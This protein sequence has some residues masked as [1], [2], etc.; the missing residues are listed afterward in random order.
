LLAIICRQKRSPTGDPAPRRSGLSHWKEPTLHIAILGAGGFIG[1]HLVEHLIARGTHTVTGLDRSGEKLAGISGEGFSF[2]EADIRYNAPLVE[3]MVREADL[4]VD[5]IA[6]ANPSLYVTRPLD[7]FELNFIQNLHIA[8]LCG[9]YRKRLI[10]YSSAEVYGKAI[11]DTAYSE[12]TTDFVFGPVHKQRWIYGSAKALLE[13]VLYAYGAADELEYTIVRPFNFVG[14]RMDYLVGPNEF[15]GPRVFP[16]FMSALLHGGP[17]HLVDGGH[18]RR[19]FLHIADGTRAFQLLLDRYDETRNRIYNVGNPGNNVSI[20]GLAA[21]MRELY[22]E[23]TG[24][25][26]VSPMVSIAGEK[27]YGVGYEDSDRSPPDIAKMRALGW[28]PEHDLRT[29]LRDT[30]QH[31]LDPK[32]ADAAT[33]FGDSV[34]AQHRGRSGPTTESAPEPSGS[35]DR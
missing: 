14:N 19:A 22:E 26:P 2:I 31:Y 9:K 33:A 3:S 34:R 7:V 12:D 5:L 6:H 35:F 29:T 32:S 25:P 17:M 23:L 16:H 28:E 1:S 10:Q 18:A 30:M 8:K 20:R 4:V 24:R 11:T 21:L 15:A 27:F 13:R